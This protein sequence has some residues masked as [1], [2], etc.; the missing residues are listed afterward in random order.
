MAVR[1]GEGIPI[2]ELQ[3]E[4]VDTETPSI[5]RDINN[6]SPS[7]PSN[8]QLRVF[9]RRLRK[10]ETYTIARNLRI[11]KNTTKCY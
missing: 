3:A 8:P 10:T 5:S 11:C 7:T 9:G 6:D 1:T 2:P 4:P